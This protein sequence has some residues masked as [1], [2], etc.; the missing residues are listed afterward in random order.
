[1]SHKAMSQIT[2]PRS[3]TGTPLLYEMRQETIAVGDN[4]AQD[5]SEEKQ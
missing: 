5:N 3:I 4:R 2:C 1:M